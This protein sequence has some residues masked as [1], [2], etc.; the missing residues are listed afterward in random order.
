[1]KKHIPQLP[2]QSDKQYQV[3]ALQPKLVAVPNM[4]QWHVHHIDLSG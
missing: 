2:V 3:N 1:M 4:T